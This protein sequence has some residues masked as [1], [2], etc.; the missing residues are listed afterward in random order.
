MQQHRV[1]SAGAGLIPARAWLNV[2]RALP[3]RILP[4]LQQ[5]TARHAYNVVWANSPELLQKYVQI[6]HPGPQTLIR[7]HQLFA[8]VVNQGGMQ[9]DYRP[10]KRARQGCSTMMSTRRLC[11][12][13]A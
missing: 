3:E 4:P 6:A 8:L 2:C 13:N 11:A 1:K 12:L 5:K 9:P 7:T 10:V